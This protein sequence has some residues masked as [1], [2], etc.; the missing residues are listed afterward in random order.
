[1]CALIIYDYAGKDPPSVRTLSTGQFSRKEAL[2]SLS[3]FATRV[4]HR[5][6][7]PQQ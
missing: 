4:L 1:M 6:K 5:V 7:Q 3:L 2:T